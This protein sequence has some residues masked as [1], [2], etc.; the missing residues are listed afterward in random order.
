VARNGRETA[1]NLG[2][3]SHSAKLEREKL[4]A[5]PPTATSGPYGARF[6]PGRRFGEGKAN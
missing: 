2:H 1:N 6:T 3:P 4:L 5:L